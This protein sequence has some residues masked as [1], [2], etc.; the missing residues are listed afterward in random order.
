MINDRQV[1]N[2]ERKLNGYIFILFF[3]LLSLCVT[4]SLLSVRHWE[5][6]ECV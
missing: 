1:S 2:I 5:G 6:G 4:G 3:I